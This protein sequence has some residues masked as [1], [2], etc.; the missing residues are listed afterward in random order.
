MKFAKEDAKYIKTFGTTQFAH[1]L[2]RAASNWEGEWEYKYVPKEVDES[3][4]P[5]GDCTPSV[6]ELWQ[7]VVGF[8]LQS[9]ANNGATLPVPEQDPSF[10]GMNKT[11]QI[12]HFWH[13]YLQHI[14]LNVLEFCDE[15]A[16]EKSGEK[17]WGDRPFEHT[18]GSADIAPL[19][20]P[21]GKEL[22]VDFKT[23]GSYAFKKADPPDWAID[24]WECQMN[25]YMDLFD[26]DEAIIVGINKDSP[27]DFKEFTY[28]KNQPLIDAIYDKWKLVSMCVYEGVEPP[29]DEDIELPL[30]GHAK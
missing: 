6:Y 23:M 1:H 22:L 21:N 8:L 9:Q 11:F 27:H 12:G 20:L 19:V 18:S 5:S 26:L 14:T 13:Q 2:D 30:Q 7:G 4:H 29:V 24:K 3:W 15:G 17:R 10:N 16:I 25:I 28:L